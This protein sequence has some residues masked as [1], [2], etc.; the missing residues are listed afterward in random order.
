MRLVFLYGPPGVGK[1]T[2]GSALAAL[3]GCKLFHNHL[4]V[5]LVTSLFPPN[6]AA[7]NRLAAQIRR[8][9]FTEAAQEGV[10]L[11]L[12]RAPRIAD[13]AE[14]ARVRTM[15]EPVRAAGGAILFV[16]LVCDREELLRRVQRDERLTQRK[17]TDPRV[18][19]ELYDLTTVLPFEPQL[20]LDVTATPPAEAALQIAEHFQLGLDLLAR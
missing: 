17:L 4:T 18:L 14:V 20:R 11:I 2:V 9:V 8:A 19:V 3:T 10:D 12:T 1:L 5:N 13:Q 15:I 7:W 6:S 16:Q